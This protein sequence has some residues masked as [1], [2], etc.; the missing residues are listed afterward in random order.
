MLMTREAQEC[1]ELAAAVTP[2][3]SACVAVS[4]CCLRTERAHCSLTASLPL[5]VRD[6]A[7]PG[8][9]LQLRSSCEKGVQRPQ[10]LTACYV[11]IN[12]SYVHPRSDTAVAWKALRKHRH[13]KREILSHASPLLSCLSSPPLLSLSL[14]FLFIALQLSFLLFRDAH[15]M[16]CLP[17]PQT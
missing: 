7:R 17:A 6:V 10:F 3:A 8:V 16:S 11:C 15:R 9:R 12:Y 13:R 2:A 5:T 14:L 1:S 4:W